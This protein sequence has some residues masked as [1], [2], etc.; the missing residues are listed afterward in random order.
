MIPWAQETVNICKQ[1]FYL[2]IL[3]H[4]NDDLFRHKTFPNRV[5][6]FGELNV[7]TNAL[8]QRMIVTLIAN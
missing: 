4:D 7:L 8:K 6:A 3:F 2:L 1:V 5:E